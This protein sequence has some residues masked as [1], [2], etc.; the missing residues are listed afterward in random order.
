MSTRERQAGNPAQA[1]QMRAALAGAA[2]VVVAVAIAAG[3]RFIA[4]ADADN[5]L[6]PEMLG[7]C[8]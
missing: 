5:W 4:F 3:T 2:A 1:E 8:C 6:E 7:D